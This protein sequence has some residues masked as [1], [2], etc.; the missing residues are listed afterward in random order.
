MVLFKRQG[1]CSG[2]GII[3]FGL[4]FCEAFSLQYWSFVGK[5]NMPNPAIHLNE[6]ILNSANRYCNTTVQQ[7]FFSSNIRPIKNCCVALSNWPQSA[8]KF[9]LEIMIGRAPIFVQIQ[10]RCFLRKWWK[11]HPNYVLLGAV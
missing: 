6:I 9:F 3:D 11:M 10:I 8:I 5:W 7:R 1:S 2:L 4:I